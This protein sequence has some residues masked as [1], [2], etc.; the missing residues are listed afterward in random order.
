A[1]LDPNERKF[2]HD[3]TQKGLAD[4]L[5]GKNIEERRGLLE[6][7]LVPN[8]H[9]EDID[10]Y[11]KDNIGRITPPPK[12]QTPYKDPETGID[13]YRLTT[14]T[15]N[16][17]EK[18]QNEE[19]YRDLYRTM[20]P[21]Y[22]ASLTE[23]RKSDPQ[24]DPILTDQ[25]YYV[26]RY[27]H[28][29]QR[30]SIE[31]A[32]RKGSGG[33]FDIGGVKDVKMSLGEHRKNEAPIGGRA[34]NDRYDFATNKPFQVSTIR[35][36]KAESM[37][38]EKEGTTGWAPIDYSGKVKAQLLFY[39]VK[40]KQLIFKADETEDMPYMRKNSIFAVPIENVPEAKDFPITKDDGTKGKLGDVIGQS[41]QDFVTKKSG[42]QW[43]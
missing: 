28:K 11:T 18:K 6:K 19:E 14:G 31:K 41:N 17:K 34:F 29:Y 20:K 22:K 27:T 3:E 15:M 43:K 5:N 16:N 40:S 39:D 35:G 37:P 25:E 36:E 24:N 1:K 32:G 7:A 23:I 9:I 42:I 10:K 4:I 30:E 12:V 2:K 13:G 38:D 21:S 33:G 8:P 26:D